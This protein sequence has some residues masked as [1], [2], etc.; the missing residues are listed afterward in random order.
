MT[1]ENSNMSTKDEETPL[2]DRF[3]PAPDLRHREELTVPAPP[4]TVYAAVGELRPEHLR[5]QLVRL[6]VRLRGAPSITGIDLGSVLPGHHWVQLGSRPGREI[7]LGT[8]GR[9]WKPQP[10]GHEVGTDDHARQAAPDQVGV[11]WS[12]RVDPQA[13][14]GSRLFVEMRATAQSRIERLYLRA[15]TP[16]ARRLTRYLAIA[17]AELAIR[18]ENRGSAAPEQF[19]PGNGDS[20]LD[21]AEMTSRGDATPTT[22]A[23]SDGPRAS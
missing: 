11:A 3:L 18:A 1:T 6:L 7:A 14:G 12:F 22:E 20:A 10:R 2:L 9:F 19:G 23:G 17:V 5:S 16:F 21:T 4:D 8:E 13:A 15:L